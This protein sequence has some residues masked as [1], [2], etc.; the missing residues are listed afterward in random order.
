MR[1]RSSIFA[2]V[3]RL[4][5][6]LLF[7]QLCIPIKA[8]N[9]RN[10]A[11]PTTDVPQE[12]AL[13]DAH[14]LAATIPGA[15]VVLIE[16]KSMRPHFDTGCLVIIKQQPFNTLKPGATVLYCTSEDELVLHRLVEKSPTGWSV[17]GLNNV[18]MDPE[19]VTSQNYKGVMYV[20]FYTSPGQN[21]AALQGTTVALAKTY[22]PT[23][24]Q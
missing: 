14:K 15:T 24:K 10:I 12:L 23:R 9:L 8:V 19:K 5:I 20:T 2:W 21:L 1:L 6:P 17:E 3:K 11:A 13:S 7:I 4:F 22:T 18:V 16:G